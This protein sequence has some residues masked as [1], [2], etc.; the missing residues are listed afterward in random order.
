MR[1]HSENER[2]ALCATRRCG[3]PAC[4]IARAARRINALARY[5]RGE[6]GELRRNG[7]FVKRELSHSVVISASVGR[8]I[9]ADGSYRKYLT[10]P[11]AW[12]DRCAISARRKPCSI[13]AATF[14]PVTSQAISKFQYIS[15]IDPPRFV[16]R[17][18]N[19]SPRRASWI[20]S[21][22]L[23]NLIEHQ[24]PLLSVEIY[25]YNF[26]YIKLNN[27]GAQ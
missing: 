23:F 18:R 7:P 27:M 11:S 5:G 12:I 1:S 6:Y 19:F 15:F 20:I 8:I 3:G 4:G 9:S 17:I 21:H 13:I 2:K 26:F 25:F 16:L 22:R 10:R 24:L 14:S